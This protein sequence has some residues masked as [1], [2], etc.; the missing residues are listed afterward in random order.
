[1]CASFLLCPE[2]NVSLEPFN[3]HGSF[4]ILCG[5][6]SSKDF[7][8]WGLERWL[9]GY[10]T[11]LLFQRTWG[12]EFNSQQFY[13]DSQASIWCSLLACR[14]PCRSLIHKILV[15]LKKGFW[16]WNEFTLRD[17]YK[18]MGSDINSCDH[19]KFSPVGQ[20]LHIWAPGGMLL[21][22]LCNLSMR[23]FVEW[24]GSWEAGMMFH[25]PAPL[26]DQALLPVFGQCDQSPHTL[27][28]VP[29][30]FFVKPQSKISS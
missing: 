20:V 21:G 18:I 27:S 10:K 8:D 30:L 6:W 15:N 7:W 29:S 19:R 23:S 2:D 4:G 14:H 24:K 17:N 11:W 1:M 22:W 12:P 5:V 26:A 28:M 16:D 25:I 13:G 9:S 3:P